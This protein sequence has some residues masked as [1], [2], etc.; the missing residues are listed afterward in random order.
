AWL[1]PMKLAALNLTAGEVLSA[2]Q[3]QNV[4]VAAGNV[5]QQPVPRGQDYQLVLNTLGR[6][7][8]TEQF[9]DIV[10]KVGEGGRYVRLRDVAR[11]DLG[12]QNS[13]LNCT[14]S[15]TVADKLVHDPSVALA[16]FQLPQANALDPADGV[17]KKME[18]LKRK[19][20][21]GLD[22]R[23]AYDTTPFIRHSVEDVFHT[24]VIA[25][26]LVIVV[27]LVF[28]QD[29]HAML[30]PMMDIVVAIIGTFVIMK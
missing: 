13:D 20:P 4:V 21:Q 27:V 9:G 30:L 23:I 5:G 2:I 16:I 24:I 3:E 15:T 12:A 28:I 25:A 6:L 7:T 19:F 17:K 1:D 22:Y 29:W 14:L 11:L 8:T 26:L 18:Q 10:V